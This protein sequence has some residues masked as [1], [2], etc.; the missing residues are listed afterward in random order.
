MLVLYL[1]GPKIFIATLLNGIYCQESW[2][3]LIRLTKDWDVNRACGH[4]VLGFSLLG[5]IIFNPLYS[6][7]TPVMQTSF[8]SLVS[9]ISSVN[10]IFLINAIVSEDPP[11]L[12]F[13]EGYFSGFQGERISHLAHIYGLVNGATLPGFIRLVEKYVFCQK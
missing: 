7:K 11:T 5:L 1:Y 8:R 2:R 4:S 10:S 3:K 12:N 13:K 6:L 9:F